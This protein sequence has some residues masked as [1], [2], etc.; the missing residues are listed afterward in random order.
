MYVGSVMRTNL[1]TVS[2]GTT[3]SEAMDTLR[4]KEIGHLLVIDT[5]GDLVGIV[6]DRDIKQNWASPATTLST[7]E[8]NYLLDQ[9]TVE[10]LMIKNVITLDTAT[11]IERAAS[12][13][14]DSRISAIP[15]MHDEKL[16]GII[17][18]HDVMGVLLEGIGISEDSVRL[19]VLARDRIGFLAEMS[20]LL[21]EENINIQSLFSWPRK[22]HPGISNL[23]L[24][25]PAIDGEKA[26]TVLKDNGFKVLTH[27]VEDITPYLPGE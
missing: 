9:V 19:T 17:T 27:Y 6:S 10:M 26:L 16:V 7:H 8:L 22:K 11:T 24:R 21:K 15:V 3:L 13:M 25:V 1:V 14:Q 12:V 2:P 5:K 18:A 4:E 23:V 20:K